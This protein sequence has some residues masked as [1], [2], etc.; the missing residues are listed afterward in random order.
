MKLS[1][2]TLTILKNF[3]GINSGIEF[4]AGD[5]LSTMSPGKTILAKAKLKDSFP[6]AFCVFDLN[7]FL[8]V[9]SLYKDPE[10]KFDEYNVIFSAGRSKTTYRKTAKEMIITPPDKDLSLPSVDAEFKLTEDTFAALMKS[11]NVLQSPNISVESDGEKIFVTCYNSKDDSAH[12]YST[13]VGESTNVFKAVF[14]TENWKMIP[15]TYDVK[16]SSRG[17]AEFNHTTQDV[18]YWIAIEAKESKFGG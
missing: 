14:L 6:E 11:A 2:D 10:L 7:Q 13:E 1:T 5:T 18:D 3:A 15:G 12:T 4:R 8:S 17:L 16:I 9:H